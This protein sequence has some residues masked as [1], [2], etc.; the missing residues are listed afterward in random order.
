[1]NAACYLL[2]AA[3]RL[4]LAACCLLLAACRLLLAAYYI[5]QVDSEDGWEYGVTVLGPSTEGDP[6]EMQVRFADGVVDDWCVCIYMPAIDRSLMIPNTDAGRSLTSE[7]RRRKAKAP[8]T[9]GT[10]PNQS[11]PVANL[12]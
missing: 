11:P 8:S 3:C 9:T 5:T 12:S 7:S 10:T 2:L 1:M 4:L 6:L